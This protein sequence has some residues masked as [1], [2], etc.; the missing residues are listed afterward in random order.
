MCS[1]NALHSYVTKAA[2]QGAR[3]DKLVEKL[4]VGQKVEEDVMEFEGESDKD[5]DDEVEVD[6]R[7]EV[8]VDNNDEDGLKEK[9][10]RGS[11]LKCRLSLFHGSLMYPH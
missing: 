6:N 8:E 10:Y 2:C 1:A 7:D 11:Q 5:A 9:R 4:M 3:Y